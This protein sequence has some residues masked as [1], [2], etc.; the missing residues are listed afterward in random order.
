MTDPGVAAHQAAEQLSGLDLQD[1]SSQA[2][3]GHTAEPEAAAEIGWL[4]VQVSAPKRR[5]RRDKIHCCQL[6]LDEVE[7][8]H[9][10]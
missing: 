1:S 5:S 3:S 9:L 8:R 10:D 7:G 4:P 2:A 6:H